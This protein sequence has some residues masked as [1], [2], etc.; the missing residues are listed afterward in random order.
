M[1]GNSRL[2]VLVSLVVLATAA[3]AQENVATAKPR[4]EIV[5]SKGRMV[6]E[7]EPTLAP[8]TVENFLAYVDAKHYD[9]LIFHRVI[10]NFMIQGGGFDK[11]MNQK[12][13]NAPI[14]NE[15]KTGLKNRRGTI[16]MART[17]VPD[18]ATAQ[19]FINVVDNAFLDY[20]ND[21]PQGIGYAAFGTV[22][23]GM[24]VA[25]AIAK[26]RTGTDRATGMRDVPVEPVV[27]ETIRRIDTAK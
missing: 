12:K 11:A 7:L 22:I 15:A 1:R 23:E 18:S 6:V 17:H 10:P 13:T 9:G 3:R 20:K 27:I 4:V 2:L 5:T 26:V 24:D 25:D 8:K 14:K 16:A 19:F 21:S